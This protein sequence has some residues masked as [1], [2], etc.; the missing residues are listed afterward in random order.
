MSKYKYKYDIRLIDGTILEFS[1]KETI[2]GPNAPLEQFE[3]KYGK[4]F[5]KKE[6]V[7]FYREKE[8]EE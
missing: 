4:M 2:F 1:T 6:N 7:L 5:I 8:I 3:T